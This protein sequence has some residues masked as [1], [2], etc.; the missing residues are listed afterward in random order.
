MSLRSFVQLVLLEGKVEDLQKK[1][2]WDPTNVSGQTKNQLT[3]QTFEHLAESDPS[4]TKKYLEWM[5]KQKLMDSS[6]NRISVNDIV[7]TIKYFHKNIH[8]FKNKDINFY[9]NLKDLENL[10]KEL[11]LKDEAL[12]VTGKAE[13]LYEDE[14]VLLVRP[15]DKQA[16][17]KYGAGT[18]W[19]ITMKNANYYEDY[20]SQ[21]IIFYFL[22]NKTKDGFSNGGFDLSK[23]AFAVYRN[24]NNDTKEIEY[25]DAEDTSL[26][27]DIVNDYLEETHSITGLH[28]IIKQDAK[29]QPKCM[30]AKIQSGDEISQNELFEYW[31]KTFN[32]LDS[33]KPSYMEKTERM[34]LLGKLTLDQQKSLSAVDKWVEDTF[35]TNFA[36]STHDQVHLQNWPTLVRTDDNKRFLFSKFHT[37]NDIDRYESAISWRDKEIPLQTLDTLLINQNIEHPKFDSIRQLAQGDNER[38][39]VKYDCYRPYDI[40]NEILI[41]KDKDGNEYS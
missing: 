27:E 1:Y 36:F 20:I 8:K 15:D 28:E 16:V 22:I 31:K 35:R 4:P 19:C 23:I 24:H 12:G 32:D 6:S 38:V 30:S 13:K 14:T 21:N 3:P 37:K 39:I 18:K 17:Q 33:L 11:E 25:F 41:F 26:T 29:K 2:V 34:L 10:V 5:I 9:K 40:M 7:P